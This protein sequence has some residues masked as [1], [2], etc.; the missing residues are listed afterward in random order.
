MHS[1]KKTQHIV[2]MSRQEYDAY[3]KR[4]MAITE[5]GFKVELI[6]ETA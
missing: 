3:G 5:R 4:L 2:L 1:E 6:E